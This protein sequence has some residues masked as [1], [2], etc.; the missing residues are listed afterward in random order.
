MNTA[1][2]P[3]GESPLIRS[4]RLSLLA[5]GLKPHTIGN[6]LRE[7]DRLL[8]HSEISDPREVTADDTRQFIGWLQT[9]R[10]AGL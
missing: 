5:D 8:S 4:F 3:V 9:Q 6:Y 7:V 1:F 2:G 10:S